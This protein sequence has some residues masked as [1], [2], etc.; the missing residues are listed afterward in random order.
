MFSAIILAAGESKRFGSPKQL[1][2]INNHTL[3]EHAISAFTGIDE[4]I[5]VLGAHR[6]LIEPIL[7]KNFTIAVNE[8]F[9]SGQTSSLLCGLKKVSADTQGVF[10][11][12]VDCALVNPQTV[13]KIKEEFT[14]HKPLIAIP[15]FNAHKGHPP[16]YS[17]KLLNELTTLKIE[18]P[19]YTINR[20]YEKETLLVEVDDE[21][22][23]KNI[24]TPK[25]V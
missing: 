24:N 15:V 5:I 25:D 13:I 11:L 21:N 7:P 4:I 19:L 14:K 2:K 23:L 12:P 22:V 18:E 17:A 8:N 1:F 10:V 9:K 3:I 20:K 16:L 6:E